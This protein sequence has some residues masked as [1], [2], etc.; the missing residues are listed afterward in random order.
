LIAAVSRAAEL[1]VEPMSMVLFP[2]AMLPLRVSVSKIEREPN[3]VESTN[4][5]VGVF[6]RLIGV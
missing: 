5:L 1:S 2:I 6:V 4:P 3:V